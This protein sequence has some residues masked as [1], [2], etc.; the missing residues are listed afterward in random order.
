ME[1]HVSPDGGQIAQYRCLNFYAKRD[2]CLKLSLAIKNKWSSR[3]T[4]LWFYCCVPC[5]RCFGGGKSVYAL[6]SWM[7]ELDY[8][9]DPE[10][11]CLDNDPND[12]T[13]VRATV[14]IEGRD[15]VEEYTA[16]KIF[17]LAASFGFGSVPL[18]T[19]PVSRVETPLPLFAVGTIAA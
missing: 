3:W 9:V 6:H 8:V 1:D 12:T 4:R 2:D 11:E 10:V 7:G 15:A 5:R 17:P 19:T 18:G 13:F 16:C 14:I